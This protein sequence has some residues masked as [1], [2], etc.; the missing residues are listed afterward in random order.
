MPN[1]TKSQSTSIQ[2]VAMSNHWLCKIVQNGY[3]KLSKS[4]NFR[5]TRKKKQPCMNL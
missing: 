1:I 3:F 5:Q 2:I 4:W